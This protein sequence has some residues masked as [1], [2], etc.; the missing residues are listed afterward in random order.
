VER[1]IV[2]KR[3]L[4]QHWRQRLAAAGVLFIA[5]TTAGTIWL[6]HNP[7]TLA[8]IVDAARARFGPQPVAQVETVVFDVQDQIRQARYRMTG[9]APE[10]RWAD[11][12]TQ[13]AKAAGAA[14]THASEP[15]SSTDLGWSPYVL[16]SDNVLLL[17]RTFVSP[18]VSRSDIQAALV[19]MNLTHTQLHVVAGTTEPISTIA[20]DRPGIIPQTVLH[21]NSVLAAFNGGFKAANGNYGMAIDHTILLPPIDGIAT[22]A[23]YRDDT[24]RIGTWGQDIVPSPDLVAFRQNCPLIL[25]NGKIT[26]EVSAPISDR[27]GQTVGNTVRTWRSGLGLSADG[28]TLIYAVGDNLTVPALAEAL[29]RGGAARAMQLDINGLSTHFVT[30]IPA[31]SGELQAQKLLD[32]T[33]G[34]TQQFIAPSSRDFFYLTRR[35]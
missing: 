17:E 4:W 19:R 27:W 23:L 13:I 33:Q 29:R 15:G 32:G 11:T 25:N 24:V 21:S 5:M 26:P 34:G 28:Q 20:T 7:D 10:L 2:N 9:V 22:I 16:G 1:T 31:A 8:A 12:P 18:D 35:D 14:A 3:A 30:F 6:D